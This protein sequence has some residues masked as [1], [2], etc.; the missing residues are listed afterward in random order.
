MAQ[1][2]SNNP[3]Y[4]LLDKVLLPGYISMNHILTPLPDYIRITF[5]TIPDYTIM[6][7]LPSP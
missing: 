6:G 2:G 5:N 1:I 3:L 7:P 4:I